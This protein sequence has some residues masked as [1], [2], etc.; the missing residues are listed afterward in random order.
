MLLFPRFRLI[1][2]VTL[3]IE[4]AAAGIAA[5]PHK[6]TQTATATSAP[7][8]GKH[9]LWRVTDVPAPFYVLGS[10]HA[11]R[12][13]DYPLGQPIIDSISQCHR[14]LFEFDIKHEEM[15]KKL[16]DAA[17][18]PKGV[19]LKDR[20]SPK[21]Y[22]F[23]RK[24]AR[25]APSTYDPYKPWA[26]AMFMYSNSNAH[27]ISQANGVEEYVLHR[28]R[29]GAE[30]AGLETVDQHIHVLS[31]MSDTEA[32]VFLLQ[33]LVHGDSDAK[34]FGQSVAA[35]KRGDTH[36]LAR[37]CAPEEREAPYI[38]Q[39]IVTRRNA[40]WIPK[41]EA[42]MQSGKPT[43]IVVGARHLCG[44]YNVID[45]LRAKGHKLEQL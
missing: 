45:L 28:A 38:V 35:Y 2:A 30:V 27:D 8:A 41:I 32:E 13:S 25:T 17:S 39:R 43:M 21:T 36:G 33:T 31:D 24:I 7:L 37:L 29:M 10:Y 18:Y 4:C 12:S 20:V 6:P 9:F 40:N 3:S 19:S 1:V 14:F 42:E 22:A 5:T 16:K 34:N 44:P 23:I 26:M 15:G 11:L